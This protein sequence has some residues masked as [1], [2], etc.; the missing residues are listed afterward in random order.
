MTD[1]KSATSTCVDPP[2]STGLVDVVPGAV[3]RQLQHDLEEARLQVATLTA[4]LESNREI[5]AAVGIVMQRHLLTREKA[6]ELLRVV[7][8]CRNRKLRDIAR[9]VVDTGELDLEP[10]LFPAARNGRSR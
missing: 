4:A 8:Q 7:S 3:C 9:D 6:F 5:G 10:V 2:V 1:Q